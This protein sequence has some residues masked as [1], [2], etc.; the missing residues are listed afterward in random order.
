MK[1]YFYHDIS[2]KDS[3]R[4]QCIECTKQYH[5]NNKEKRN[6]RE[7]TRRVVD[8]NYRLITNT[9]RRI[10]HALNGRLKSSSTKDI[11]GIDIDLYRKWIEYQMTP[12]MNWNNI[13][14]DHVK[15]ICLF[16]VSRDEEL[17]DAFN[18]KNTQ[19]LLKH[20]HQQKGI[21]FNFL[22]HQN[23]FIKAYQFI[24]LN[25]ERFNENIH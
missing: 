22:D 12:E 20:E 23:Q 3:L 17:K 5:S 9:R 8:V 2:K 16:D 24:K 7:R 21:K 14:I 18:W 25:E 1:R 10:H 6:L 11:I 4:N 13:E 15:A 19:P